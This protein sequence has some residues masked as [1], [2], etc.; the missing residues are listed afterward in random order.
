MK[1]IMWNTIM[2][3]EF[4]SLASLTEEENAVLH[5]W[6]LGKSIVATAMRCHMSERKVNSLRNSIRVKY[7]AVQIYTP[8]LPKRP[9]K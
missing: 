4:R 7:D 3:R 1:D 5:D 8:L 2:L 9:A 6:A